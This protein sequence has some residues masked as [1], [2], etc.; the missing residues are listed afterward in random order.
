MLRERGGRIKR[1]S[2]LRRGR[3]LFGGCVCR[4]RERNGCAAAGVAVDAD[5]A[6]VV[7]DDLLAQAQPEAEPAGAA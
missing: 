6:A 4:Q 1:L 2:R 3:G 7:F 5:E